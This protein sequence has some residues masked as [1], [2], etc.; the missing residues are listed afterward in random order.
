MPIGLAMN[1]STDLTIN[2]TP[3]V[4]ELRDKVP[5]REHV[6]REVSSLQTL[7]AANIPMT[8]PGTRG[9]KSDSIQFLFRADVYHP[10]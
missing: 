9:V 5:N 7:H 10:L 4:A 6:K 1:Y 8:L 3:R 2:S